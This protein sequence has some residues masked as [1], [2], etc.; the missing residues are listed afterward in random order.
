[1]KYIRS[2]Y[3]TNIWLTLVVNSTG[4]STFSSQKRFLES[5]CSSTIPPAAGDFV[6]TLPETNSKFAPEN[7]CLE[8][9][10][11]FPFGWNGPF[12]GAKML[13]GSVIWDKPKRLHPPDWPGPNWGQDSLLWALTTITL[14]Y[15]I[16]NYIILYCIYNNIYIYVYI[17]AYLYHE[18]SSIPADGQSWYFRD[19]LDLYFQFKWTILISDFY[20]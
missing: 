11:S 2:G 18:Q 6:I 15:T 17:Y 5:F 19:G 4:R 14:Y 8:Y 9:I 20:I 3:A 16:S 7:G 10:Q 1:M 13:V 12:S